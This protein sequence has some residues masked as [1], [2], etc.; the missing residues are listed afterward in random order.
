MARREREPVVFDLPAQRGQGLGRGDARLPAQGAGR[1]AGG[2]SP[3]DPI[4]TGLEGV[5]DGG[6]DRGLA[7][8]GHALD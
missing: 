5:P 7:R 2:R 1:L 6:H 4:P 3:D 8:S